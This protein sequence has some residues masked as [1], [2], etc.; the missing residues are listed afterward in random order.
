MVLLRPVVIPDLVFM[1]LAEAEAAMKA[2]G[3]ERTPT[4]ADE[5]CGPTVDD[6]I[7][8]QG[9]I[10]YQHPGA[11]NK[12][13]SKLNV[14]VRVQKDNP[15]DRRDKSAGWI[16]MPDLR[17]VTVEQAKATLSKEGFTGEVKITHVTQANCKANTVCSTFPEHD[18]RTGATTD[19]LLYIGR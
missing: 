12:S 1:T 4:V 8:E 10:C 2:A 18:T 9:R 5:M 13:G 15:W 17:G 16:F 11:G 14:Y 6:K 3:I 19:K 7:V